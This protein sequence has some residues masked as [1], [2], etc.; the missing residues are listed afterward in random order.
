[1]K[2]IETAKKSATN[3]RSAVF[4]HLCS[5][6]AKPFHKTI[7][8]RIPPPQ[9]NKHGL[10]VI[11]NHGSM[12]II[13]LV[14]TVKPQ[15]GAS[16]VLSNKEIFGQVEKVLGIECY[17]SI[18]SIDRKANGQYC[19]NGQFHCFLNICDGFHQHSWI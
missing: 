15:S 4:S 1:M 18:C 6:F 19:K 7:S 17:C 8:I 2:C 9:R 11:T 14:S 16:T 12:N 13:K 10:P 3:S 5:L